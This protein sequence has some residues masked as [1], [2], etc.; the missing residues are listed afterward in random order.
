[1]K[2]WLW[3]EAVCGRCSKTEEGFHIKV[4]PKRKTVDSSPMLKLQRVMIGSGWTQ[5]GDELYCKRCSQE[6]KAK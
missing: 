5:D 1:M 2:F 4:D 6:R 3:V